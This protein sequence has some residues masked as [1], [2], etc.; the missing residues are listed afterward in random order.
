MCARRRA[1][2]RTH[3]SGVSCCWRSGSGAGSARARPHS[4]TYQSQ[5]E[6]LALVVPRDAKA[7]HGHRYARVV[8]LGVAD[9]SPRAGR[10]LLFLLALP[11]DERVL[12]LPRFL[13]G[14]EVVLHRLPPLRDALQRLA[15]LACSELLLLRLE[16]LVALHVARGAPIAAATA[17]SQQKVKE[18]RDEHR[19][20]APTARAEAAAEVPPARLPL[21]HVPRALHGA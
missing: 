12:A 11:R 7:G 13:L 4:A 2:A 17:T 6:A 18:S 10:L 9:L 5:V 16:S 15:L 19:R 20:V 14:I 21:G 3:G 1:N 8:L